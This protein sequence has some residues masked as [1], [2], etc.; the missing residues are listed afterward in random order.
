MDRPGR[1]SANEAVQQPWRAS[2]NPQTGKE[3]GSCPKIRDS[4]PAL[5]QATYIIVRV[6]VSPKT[7]SRST[8]GQQGIIADGSLCGLR[9]PTAIPRQ[10]PSEPVF[11]QIL[12]FGRN[13]PALSL[14]MIRVAMAK[15]A[16]ASRRGF[17]K[18]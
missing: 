3:R 18:H 7:L 2:R 14:R 9:A 6:L 15:Q 17:D 16:T 4:F 10:E 11:G 1:A 5:T 12:R 13:L 8:E